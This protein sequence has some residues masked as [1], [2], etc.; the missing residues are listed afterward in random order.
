MNSLP[1]NK[2]SLLEHVFFILFNEY[3]FTSQT[4]QAT[5][6]F[7]ND[8]VQIKNEQDMFLFVAKNTNMIYSV[9]IR[10]F[11]QKTEDENLFLLSFYFLTRRYYMIEQCFIDSQQRGAF[12]TSP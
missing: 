6:S 5:L 10:I 12:A 8:S 9:F 7:K 4:K 2:M 11:E 1:Q 3:N